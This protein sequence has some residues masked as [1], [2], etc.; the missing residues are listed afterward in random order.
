MLKDLKVS[1]IETL[2][3]KKRN[4]VKFVFVKLLENTRFTQIAI[5]RSRISKQ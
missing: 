2:N 1:K 5:F 4:N 3:I